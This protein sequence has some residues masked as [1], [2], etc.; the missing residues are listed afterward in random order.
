MNPQTNRFALFHGHHE[1][2]AGIAAVGRAKRVY[3]LVFDN[4]TSD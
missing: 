1:F 2:T 3:F 4:S